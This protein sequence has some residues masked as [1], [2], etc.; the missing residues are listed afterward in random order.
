MVVFL[1]VDGVI[2]PYFG[3]AG[4]RKLNNIF[5]AESVTALNLLTKSLNAPIV[6]SSTRRNE[7]SLPTIRQIFKRDGI[8]GEVIG[9][10]P[11][12]G[13]I[14]YRGKEIKDWLAR[15][16][17]SSGKPLDYLVIDDIP[18]ILKPEIP[19]EKTIITNPFRGLRISQAIKKLKSYGH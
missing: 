6:V 8:K 15:H 5:W 12:F 7:W 11:T 10:T 3:N 1:D 9:V 18:E 13:K 2:F 14:E 4:N 17:N 19:D 16:C